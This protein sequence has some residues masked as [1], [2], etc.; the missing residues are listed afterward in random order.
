MTW[1]APTLPKPNGATPFEVRDAAVAIA[2]SKC[3]LARVEN[4]PMRVQIAH[5]HCAWCE[6]PLDVLMASI[7]DFWRWV[8]VP[9]E[10]ARFETLAPRVQSRLVEE[11]GQ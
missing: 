9:D 8:D 7:C 2:I 10:C 3:W 6:Y 5:N 11:A 1:R 4:M